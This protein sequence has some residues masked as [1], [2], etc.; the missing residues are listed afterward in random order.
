MWAHQ[1]RRDGSLADEVQLD[2]DY[3]VS[4]LAA[5]QEAG[6]TR[7]VKSEDVRKQD[8]RDAGGG[9]GVITKALECANE[10]REEQSALIGR[11]RAVKGDLVIAV[12]EDG[13]DR[14]PSHLVNLNQALGLK[15][16]GD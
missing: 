3:V 6:S 8:V 16:C 11:L 1:V 7:V 12:V 9:C 5:I 15:R 13:V 10:A 2:I 14:R 4:Q